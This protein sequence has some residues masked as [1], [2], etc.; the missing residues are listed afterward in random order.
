LVAAG[1]TIIM[2]KQAPFAPNYIEEMDLKDLENTGVQVCFD[3]MR[4][5]RSNLI[6]VLSANLLAIFGTDAS[7][8]SSSRSAMDFARY[9]MKLPEN[10]LIRIQPKVTIL[11]ANNVLSGSGA[12]QGTGSSVS[13]K[14]SLGAGPGE[15]SWKFAI[16]TTVFWVGE[17]AALNNPVPND[18]SAWDVGWFSNYGGY[19]SPNSD[20]RRDFIPADF[21]PRQNPFYVALPYNDVD[22]HHT[23]P[24][25]AQ[26]IP[27]FRTCFVRDGQSVCKGRWVAIRHGNRVCYA[28]WEDVG[29]YQTDHWQYVFGNE[30]P[31]PNPNKDAGL[32]VSPAVRDYLALDSIDICDWKFVDFFRVPRGPWAIYGENNTFSR[33]RRPRSTSVVVSSRSVEPF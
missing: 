1:L 20:D 5:I 12:N 31:R 2:L 10:T 3:A 7:A 11:P 32:D 6:L 28:Q 24:E 25:A 30:R 8:Q 33:L 9:A 29:P 27:W 22:D 4:S 19:D 14:N 16:S 21:I 23:K 17:Q 26:V 15:Y 18:K 13:G